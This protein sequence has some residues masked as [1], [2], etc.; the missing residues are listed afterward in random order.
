MT[1]SKI[2]ENLKVIFYGMGYC[3]NDNLIFILKSLV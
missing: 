1:E 3:K 2:I